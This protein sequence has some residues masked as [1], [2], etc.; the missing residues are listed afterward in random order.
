MIIRKPFIHLISGPMFAAKTH[1]LIYEYNKYKKFFTNFE[2]I[3]LVVKPKIDT[4]NVGEITSRSGGKIPAI[5]IKEFDEIK[6]LI[7]EKTKFIF[8]DEFQ[9]FSSEITQTLLELRDKKKI[10]VILSGLDLDFKLN[11]FE[12]FTEIKKIA[13]NN[14]FSTAI[15]FTCGQTAQYSRREILEKDIKDEQVLIEGENV[16]YFSCCKKC[17][18]V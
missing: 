9:F 5:M 12:R 16:K 15:C 18:K 13:D 10:S 8:V 3:S 6:D 14:T 1:S 11:E 17:H 4:R 7:T 2:E